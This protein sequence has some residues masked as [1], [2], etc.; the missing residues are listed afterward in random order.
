MKRKVLLL[1]IVN[2]GQQRQRVAIRLKSY[3]SQSNNGEEKKMCSLKKQ[4]CYMLRI[5]Q[6]VKKKKK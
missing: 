2:N 6:K 5:I 1:S 3:F 4:K